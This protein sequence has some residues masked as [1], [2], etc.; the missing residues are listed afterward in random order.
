MANK[1]KKQF[2]FSVIMTIYNIEN[3]LREAIESVIN[4]SLNFEENIEIILVNDGSPDNSHI[5]C[6]EYAKKFPENIVYIEKENG[7]VSSARNAGL[8]VAR[9]KIINFLDSDDYFSSNA[10]ECVKNFF[11]KEKD[12]NIVAINLINFEN[13]CGSWV[14]QEYFK[15]TQVV[16][17]TKDYHF[18]QCQVGASFIKRKWALKYRYDETIKIHED[19]H[20]LYRIFRDNTKCG[21]ISEATYWHRIRNNG[22]SATQTI[23]HKNTAFNMSGYLLKELIDFYHEKYKN[24]PSYLQTFIILEFNYYVLEKFN[25]LSMNKKEKKE[26][27]K[28]IENVIQNITEDDIN[29]H[30]FVNERIKV[31]YLLLKKNI[32]LI[33]KK[34]FMEMPENYLPFWKKVIFFVKK[35]LRFV[36]RILRYIKRKIRLP[37]SRS[38]KK[39]IELEEAAYQS[40]IEQENIKKNIE[41][42]QKELEILSKQLTDIKKKDNNDLATEIKELKKLCEYSPDEDIRHIYYFHSG[43]YNCGCEALLKTIANL[44]D[45]SSQDNALITFRK[46]E[47][48]DK[49]VNNYIKYIFEPKLSCDNEKIEYM[50]NSKFNFEDMGIENY[51]K[52]LKNKAIAFSVGGDNYC[53]GDYVNKLLAQYNRIFHKHGIKTALLGCSIEPEVLENEEVLTDLNKYDLIIARETITYKSLLE[54]GINKNTILMPDT[55]FTLK[56]KKV[57]LPENFKPD[58][59]IGINISP[60]INDYVDNKNIIIENYKKLI[61]YIIKNTDSNILFVPHVFWEKSKDLDILE[62][63]YNEYEYTNRVI[64]VKTNDAEELKYYISNCKIF[65]GARTHSLIAAYS[66]CV[67]ALAIGY[68]VKARGIALDLF[69]EYKNY[70]ISVKDFMNETDLLNA[71][72]YIEKNYKKIKR[73]LE[74]KIPEYVKPLEKY[75]AIIKK[76]YNSENNTNLPD[77]DCTGCGTCLNVCPQNCIQFKRNDEGFLYPIINYKKCTRCGLCIKKCPALQKQITTNISPEV[78]ALKSKNEELKKNSS[79]GGIFGHLASYILEQRGIVCGAAFNKDMVLEHIL[80]TN[81]SDLIKLQGSKYLQSDLKDCFKKIKTFLSNGKLVM[82]CGTPCQIKGLNAYLGREYKNL[83]LLDFICHGVPSPLVFNKYKLKLETINSSKITDFNFRNKDNGWKKYNIKSSF[84]NGKVLTECYD[85]NIYMKGFLRNLY[86]RNSCYNC[87]S[88]NFSSDSDLTLGDFWGVQDIL[89]DFDDDKGCSLL[90]INSQKGK[91]L[92]EK[93]KEN[94]ESQ[95][96]EYSSV[97]KF[98]KSIYKPAFENKNRTRFF[99]DLAQKDIIENI[100]ENLYDEV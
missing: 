84:E 31:R 48:V 28:Y 65:V 38:V 63:L 58:N 6:E 97:I 69:G 92:Y 24:I 72:K 33:Y 81:K 76:L 8:D 12:V 99:R 36:K 32:N 75:N 85:K 73:Y 34:K 53:Y 56:P 41:N 2:Y 71:Y 96:V 5:I 86:L 1:E 43:S 51:I 3:Y 80:I 18:M 37:F 94:F 9:G 66:S 21:V 77:Y 14:N 19:S 16:D 98:N 89:P 83:Y 46:E 10:F 79:S 29:N 93:I 44:C 30:P 68:S 95:K 47:D 25:F 60:L 4:Q 54:K 61:N 15:K 26:L 100:E 88:N 62:E 42:Q 7:G 91:K 82:F 39:I 67:P 64:L 70:V 22:T 78:L 52:K 11:E 55:A 49:N 57:E 13:S 50:G 17:M 87:L 45:M 20:Y 40:K 27:V 59:T 90:F 35:I 74:K 23:K